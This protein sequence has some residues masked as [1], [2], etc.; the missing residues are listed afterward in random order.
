LPPIEE[1]HELQHLN[2]SC[3]NQ[4][5]PR[6]RKTA[7]IETGEVQKI[8]SLAVAMRCDELTNAAFEIDS[9]SG[10]THELEF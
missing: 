1:S 4:E 6:D 3:P 9:S 2:F 8:H 10:T 5:N 7:I